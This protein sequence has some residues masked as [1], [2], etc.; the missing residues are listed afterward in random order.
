[1]ELV[2]IQAESTVRPQKMEVGVT[3]VYFR[4]NISQEQRTNMD[5]TQTT[6]YVYQEAQLSKDEALLYLADGQEAANK[7]LSAAI[8]SNAMLEDCLVEMAGVVYA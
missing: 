8:Q 5:G 7:K 1:M 4:K 6:R 2:Y 3:T